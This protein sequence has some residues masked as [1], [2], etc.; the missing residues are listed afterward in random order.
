MSI[1]QHA[2]GAG[3]SVPQ[4]VLQLTSDNYTAWAIK[5]EANLD[6]AG[7]GRRWWCRRTPRRR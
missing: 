7:C 3:G 4:P 1:V 5:V 6:A 2:G